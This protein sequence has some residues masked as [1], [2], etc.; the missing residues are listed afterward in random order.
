MH[1][2]GGGA[3][4]R[5]YGQTSHKADPARHALGVL[6]GDFGI[7][8]GKADQPEPDGDKQH[9]PDIGGIHAGPEQGGEQ[10]CPQDQHAAHGGRAS[11]G[12]MTGRAI[13][14]DRLAGFLA[15]A[16]QVDQRPAK[17]KT[18]NQRSKE[19]PAGAKGDVAKQVED[20]AA[21]RKLG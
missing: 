20:I 12:E 4:K 18:E 5:R 14:A 19:G 9:D 21:I 11:F 7:I 8:I 17:D 1:I 16:Q 13:I 15:A 10:Q 6:F 2:G 3:G